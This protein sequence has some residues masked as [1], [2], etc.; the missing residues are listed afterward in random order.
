MKA[1]YSPI[2]ER[3]GLLDHCPMKPN[4]QDPTLP[5]PLSGG[6]VLDAT[7]WHVFLQSEMRATRDVFLTKP[8]LLLAHVR[9]ERQTADD[10]AGREL[11]ELVQNAADA[12]TEVGGGGRVR[13]EVTP[14]GLVVANTGHPFQP[15][16]V[17]SLMTPNASDKPGRKVALIGAK[18]LG[19]RSLLNWSQEPVISS[20]ELEIG[21]SRTHAAA[22][23]AAL[24]G[25][26]PALAAM[27]ESEDEPPVPVLAFPAFGDALE[28]LHSPAGRALLDRARELRAL[29]YDTVVAAPFDRDGALER[30]IRQA[31]EFEPTFLLFVESIDQI[32]VQVTDRPL[33]R[34]RRTSVGADTYGLEVEVDGSLTEQTWICLR[35]RGEISMR[36]R[37]KPRN[38]ELAVALRVDET[39]RPGF[40]HSYFP[41]SIPLPFSALMHA[42]LE[43]DS[44]RKTIKEDSGLNELVLRDLGAF[45]AEALARLAKSKKLG[46]A[47]DFLARGAAF[48]AALEDFEST[49]YRTARQ[50]PIVPTMKGRRM[51]AENGSVGPPGYESY[52]PTRLF[53][54]LAKCRGPEDRAVLER[55]DVAELSAESL[56]RR[57]RR[58][59]LTLDERAKAVVGIARSL[60]AKHHHRSL[61]ID[62]NG[63][64][65]KDRNT[66]FPPPA[67]G[68]RLPHL[69]DW[70]KARFIH[71]ELWRLMLK[72][73][74]GQNWRDKLKKLGGFG[75][76]EYSNESV[77]ASL[78]TQAARALSRG[79]R[80]AGEV[81]RSLLR[82]VHSLYTPDN[83]NPPGVFKL[84][85][86]DGSWRDSRE[87]HL[88]QSYGQSGRINSELYRSAPQHLLGTAEENGI[89]PGAT[90]LP[91]FFEWLGVN[92]WP[93]AVLT[94][95]PED[96]RSAILRALPDQITV[97]DEGSLKTFGKSDVSWGY[98]L[99]CEA[100]SIVG[101]E[102]ILATA[103]SDAIVAWL[104]L[105]PRF[106]PVEPHH[107]DAKVT[108][109]RDGK[110]N[111]RRYLGPLP[112]LVRERIA[113]TPWLAC[114]DGRHHEPRET[115]VQPGRLTELFSVPRPAAVDSV[116]TY[117][118]TQGLWRRGLESAGVP[119]GLADLTEA[120]IFTLLKGLPER[121]A[122]EDTVRRLYQ[123]VLE[124][125]SFETD[126]APAER[127]DFL[128]NGR[129]QVHRGHARDWVRPSEA[130]YADQ[131]GFPLAAREFLSLIDLPPRRNT[132]NVAE[133]FGVAALSQQKYQLKVTALEEN[134]GPVAALLRTDLAAA[135]PYI[136]ALRLADANVTK[137]LRRF[138]RLEL[139]VAT[140]AQITVTIGDRRIE[141][142][143]EPWTHVLDGDTLIVA[144]DAHQQMSQT[145]ALAHEAMA[146]G[147]AE[148]FDLQSGADFSRLLSARDDG[149]RAILLRRMLANLSDD[150]IADLLADIGGGEDE[151]YEPVRVDAET[152][153]RGPTAPEPTPSGPVQPTKPEQ[154]GTGQNGSAANTQG[155]GGKPEANPTAVT[156]TSVQPGPTLQ[157]FRPGVRRTI[158]IRVAGPTGAVGG[159]LHADPDRAADAE[160]W[161]GLFETSQGRFPI[162]VGHLQGRDAYGCDWL[163]FASG[164]DREAFKLDP[165]RTDLVIRFIETKSGTVELTDN[166]T[167]AAEL[168]RS[169]FFIYLLEFYS[170]SRSFAELTVVR[171]PLAHRDAMI[172]RFEFRMDAVAQRE[173]F[174]LTPDETAGAC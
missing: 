138:E 53:G 40:L 151:L 111:F 43:L 85:C 132:G 133:R 167:R 165:T 117:G 158:G 81:Q 26:S 154:P 68:D 89:D 126:R 17:E 72:R 59:D 71:P 87:L 4:P 8:R 84:M 164:E 31:G 38:Y 97:H 14:E 88:S 110:E 171:D 48:P 128:A 67:G 169:R 129:V 73:I 69:P 114:R 25:E 79:R 134:A 12:A 174:Q 148:L 144:L 83:R 92:R 173:R 86:A 130:L 52:L 170:G 172:A 109:R 78:R 16:G 120:R 103:Q 163:S 66:P 93:R 47:L 55:L 143:V 23:V 50:M 121:G 54:D 46:N 100:P 123:Q 58:S 141:G 39:N 150:E 104:A 74:E 63:R 98:N 62:Q 80:D 161:T 106:D 76:S 70:A 36:G 41:T 105:D 160:E 1:L 112:D 127:A 35:R 99:K 22:E 124:L 64:P 107:F 155:P 94:E 91:A 65:M 21:F 19:F 113:T 3:P 42:T 75:I 125:E 9:S 142:P 146:D 34:W 37:R 101:L 131:A 32:E 27:C 96:M 5:I 77:I 137:R 118:L 115:M 24:A 82:T 11:L 18:G 159:T 102:D 149:L 28:D 57:L 136:R 140:A 116:D 51:S 45:Y 108:G 2:A 60:N 156:A 157:P 153:A 10:Y 122:A 7:A 30:A 95:A 15:G 145:A 6:E 33:V 56:V 147:I 166:E 29:D 168:R 162:F 20:G 119:Q 135:R 13:I 61:L 49:V 44:N 139:K 90:N 152:L